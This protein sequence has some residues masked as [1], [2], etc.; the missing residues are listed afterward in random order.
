MGQT[1]G[2]TRDHQLVNMQGQ[3]LAEVRDGTVYRGG[4]A[5]FLVFCSSIAVIQ[6]RRAFI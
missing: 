4:G 1:I 6:D 5:A 2:T 3:V